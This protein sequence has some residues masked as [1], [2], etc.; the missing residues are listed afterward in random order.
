VLDPQRTGPR[1]T[2]RSISL[3]TPT[4]SIHTGAAQDD[5]TLDQ[6]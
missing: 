6:Q 1:V 4:R 3:T 5:D 2:T